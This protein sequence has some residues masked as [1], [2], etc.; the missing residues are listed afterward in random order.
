MLPA[1]VSQHSTRL[2]VLPVNTQIS[3]LCQRQFAA[4]HVFTPAGAADGTSLHAAHCTAASCHPNPGTLCT[5]Q[6]RR[7]A[8][9]R[10]GVKGDNL[11]DWEAVFEYWAGTHWHRVNRGV[12][13]MNTVNSVLR[14]SVGH[15][16]LE[17]HR[18]CCCSVVFRRC[19]MFAD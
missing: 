12:A 6:R 10:F 16:S 2:N 17:L 7:R 14:L 15:L 9:Q 18:S 1:N 8:G 13:H 3:R 4:H 5:Q 11:A 19:N